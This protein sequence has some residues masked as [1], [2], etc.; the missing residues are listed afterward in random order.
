MRPL[1]SFAGFPDAV[2]ATAI[3][4]GHDLRPEVACPHRAR[5]RH[6][7]A[8]RGSVHRPPD[9]GRRVDGGRAPLALR[10]RPQPSAREGGVPG[11]RRRVGP[12]PVARDAVRRRSSSGPWRSYDDFYA[13][14]ARRLDDVSR[15]RIRSSCST[16]TPT[17]TGATA[18]MRRRRPPTRTPR[19]TS[20][21]AALDRERWGRV[22]DRFMD[23]LAAQRGRAARSLDVR[24]NVRF[25]GGELSRWVNE[26]YRDRG[27]ALAIEFKKVFMDE[28][29]GEARRAPPRGAPRALA[30]VVPAL[31]RRRACRVRYADVTDGRLPGPRPGRRSSA[32]RHRR[33]LPL[34][35]RRHPGRPRRCA[36]RRSGRRDARRSSSTARSTTTPP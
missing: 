33:Q 5:R 11:A 22:V 9:R 3:H 27:C 29:T 30:A 36:R 8:R 12:R 10:G 23:D 6:P 15:T 19:S 2:I 31:R 4:A 1:C 32:G 21:P 13:E 14:L 28:W 16:C 18:P 24:E 25:Q 20:A 17:T 26:R 7:A 34:P 35:A